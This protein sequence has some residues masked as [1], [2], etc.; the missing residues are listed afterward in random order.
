MESFQPVGNIDDIP[1]VESTPLFDAK[2]FE[3]KRVKIEK[4]TQIVADSHYIDGAYDANKTVKVPMIEI[5]TEIVST[6][7]TKEGPK[8]IRAKH[9]FSLQEIEGKVVISKNPKAKLWKFLRKM[10][11]DKPSL[12]VGKTITLTAEPSKDENDDRTWLR[13]VV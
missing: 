5:E 3:G 2:E 9:R 12:L 11:V 4:V 1:V 10:G 8:E 7:S 6:V 13:I